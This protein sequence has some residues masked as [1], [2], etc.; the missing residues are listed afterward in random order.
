MGSILCA[1]RGGEESI[2]T[3]QAAIRQAAASGDV[4]IFFYVVDVE[5]LARAQYTLRSD[6][7]HEE[8]AEMAE[9]LM[10]MAVERAQE[11]GVKATSLIRHGVFLDELV[12]AAAEVGAEQVILGRPHDAD[13]AE[14]LAETA[15]RLS[16]DTGIPFTILP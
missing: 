2:Q 6:I 13:E 14:R 16:K 5:F 11:Q 8:L 1:T 4:L 9:F 15:E 7:V 12:I 3:E 10:T